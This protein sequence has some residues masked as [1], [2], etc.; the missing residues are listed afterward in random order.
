M[1]DLNNCLCE[2]LRDENGNVI[3]PSCGIEKLLFMLCEQVENGSSSGSSSI[4][5]ADIDEI[6]SS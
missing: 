3:T 4:T 6:T 2:I 1:S 5:K